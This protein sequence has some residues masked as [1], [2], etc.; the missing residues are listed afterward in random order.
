[1]TAASVTPVRLEMML[2]YDIRAAIAGRPVAYLPL[3]TIEWHGEHLPVGLDAL[4]AHGV[5]VAAART[6]GGIVYPPLYYGTG[7]DH[8][9]YPWTV[10]T[11]GP[12]ELDALLALTLS[13][14]QAFGVRLA[15][16]FSGHFA[17]AQLAMIERIASGWTPDGGLRVIALAVSSSRLSL[18]PDH[19][20]MFETTLLHALHPESVKIDRLPSFESSPLQETL[21]ESC[22]S[23]RHD[24]S[25]PLYGVIGPDPR[26]FDP[27]ASG[28]LL[29]AM[30]DHVVATVREALP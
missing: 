13:R 16:L 1:M 4:T 22:G 20:G 19:A 27:R 26:A 29:E 15:V 30:V 12:H 7:G 11:A 2:P 17:P 6:D 14:L 3:G 8:A 5:C 21:E 25:H 23:R 18:P 24:A 9:L 10:M 28:V